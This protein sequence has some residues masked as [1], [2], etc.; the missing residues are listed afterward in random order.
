M[1]VKC[2]YSVCFSTFQ[3]TGSEHKTEVCWFLLN[4]KNKYKNSK[5]WVFKSFQINFKS[6][7]RNSILIENQILIWLTWILNSSKH[8]APAFSSTPHDTPAGVPCFH[9]LVAFN[10]M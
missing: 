6:N 2:F 4:N 7:F 3:V 5:D 10:E 1:H 8:Y 9:E